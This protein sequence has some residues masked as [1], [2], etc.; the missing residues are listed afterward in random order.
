MQQRKYKIAIDVYSSVL[1][2]ILTDNV[3]ASFRSIVKKYPYLDEEKDQD[4]DTQVEG[5][6]LDSPKEDFGTYYIILSNGTSSS[7]IAHEALHATF[8]I[9][10]D[11]DVKYSRGNHESFTYLHGWIYSEIE[12]RIKRN[13]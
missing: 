10:D 8:A 1:N 4:E 2:L 5:W 6:F 9:L 3:A 7:F 13:D 12:K 11:H